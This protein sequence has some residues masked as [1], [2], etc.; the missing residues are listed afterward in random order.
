[1]Q[2]MLVMMSE[3]KTSNGIETKI[4]MMVDPAAKKLNITLEV[5]SQRIVKQKNSNTFFFVLSYTHI[6]VY[7][8]NGGLASLTDKTQTNDPSI[9]RPVQ[10]D[11]A[12]L[13]TSTLG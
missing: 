7:S 10:L 1:M 11:S 5:Y 3:A 12:Q 2:S 13:L 6:P 9:W 8:I 4:T